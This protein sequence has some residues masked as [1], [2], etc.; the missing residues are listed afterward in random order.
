MLIMKESTLDLRFPCLIPESKKCLQMAIEHLL[1]EPHGVDFSV[2]YD[3]YEGVDLVTLSIDFKQPH[4]VSEV[5]KIIT[6]C[7][8]EYIFRDK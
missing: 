8:A 2:T 5:M 7:N 4:V 1:G 3:H 6:E